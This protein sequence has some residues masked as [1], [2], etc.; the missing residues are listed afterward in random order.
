[1]IAP[2]KAFIEEFS[3]EPVFCGFYVKGQVDMAK[4]VLERLK[5]AK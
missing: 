2:L 3:N 1:M 4:Q 5:G